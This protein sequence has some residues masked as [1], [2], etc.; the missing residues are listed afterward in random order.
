MALTKFIFQVSKAV[1]KKAKSAQDIEKEAK[2]KA[3]QVSALAM[4]K[5]DP[6]EM[7]KTG[8]EGKKFSKW[9]ESGIPTHDAS[10]VELTKSAQKKLKKDYDK[11]MK[12]FEKRATP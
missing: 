11:Q 6:R 9:D 4:A 5:V 1:Q 10:G 7:F 3:D 8:E 2:R 12:K